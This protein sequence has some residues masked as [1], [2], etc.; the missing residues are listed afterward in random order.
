MEITHDAPRHRFTVQLE[1]GAGELQYDELAG[2]VIDFHHTWV[3]PA[4][5]KQ[6]TAAELV[7]AGVAWARSQDRKVEPT[8]PY[9]RSWFE[10]HPEERD[11]LA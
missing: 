5:R 8:C 2:G 4:I 7:R 11:L 3:D 9:V 1:G 10:R 6:G